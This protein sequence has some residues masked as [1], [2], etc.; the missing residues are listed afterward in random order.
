MSKPSVAARRVK[1]RGIVQGVG[2][3]P[4]IYGLAQRLALCG[5]VRNTSAGVEIV[6]EGAAEALDAFVQAISAEAPPLARVEHVHAEAVPPNGYTDFQIRHSAA[7][8]G[9]YQL[10]SPDVAT[11]DECLAEIFDPHNRRYRYAFTNCTNCGPRFTIIRDIPYDRPLTTMADFRM[12]ADCQREYDDPLDRRFHAQPNACPTCGPQLELRPSP[13][14]PLPEGAQRARSGGVQG[15]AS[16]AGGAGGKAPASPSDPI[17]QARDLLRTGHIV[18]VKGL[19]GFHLA[20]DATAPQVVA[21]LRAR[22][23]RPHKPF[24]VMMPN[25]ATV[26]R[27]CHVTETAAEW[28]QSKE[29][30]IVLLPLRAEAPIAQNVAP[31]LRELGVM[32]PYTPLHHLLLEPTGDFPPALVM[33]SGNLSDEPIVTQNAAALEKLAPLADAFLLHDRAIHVRCDDSVVRAHGEQITPIRRSRG[34]V[35]NPLP[36]PFE[37]PP[38]LAVGAELKNTFCLAR[39]R[40]AF[41]SQHIGDL[42]N[43]D[44]LQAYERAVAH[45]EHIFRLRPQLLVHDLHPNYMATRYAERRADREDLARLAVQ[46]HHAHLAACIAEHAL[47]ADAHVIGVIFDGTG[48]GTDGA[49]WGGEVL[50]GGYAGFRRFA[51]LRY[52]PLPGGDAATL[53]PYRTALAHLWA[54]GLP[55]ETDLPPVQAANAQERAVIRQ[56]LEKRLN[57]PLTSS[58]GRLFD[59]AAALVGVLQRVSYEAQGAIWLEAQCDPQEHGSYPLEIVPPATPNAPHQLDPAPLWRA[60]LGDLRAGVDVPRMAARFHNGI[61]DAVVRLCRLAREHSGLNVVALSGGVF[62]NAMLL[63]RVVAG[64]RR[65]G[66]TVYAHRRVPPND[67]GLALGQAA[68][69]A[70]RAQST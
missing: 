43:Y 62:Q 54:A 10:I 27:F 4:F 67:G 51:H 19:G 40:H 36:L 44:A 45:M 33:T 37:S 66:F 1:V 15:T 39:E 53:R 8:A 65:A 2:F 64:L 52:I 46:H 21:E 57:A 29:R 68:I 28:L 25:L 5:W 7:I 30:P 24:A 34:Y 23:R 55:W 20:C 49:I 26:R 56:Q 38:L 61:A 48:L 3:R 14:A 63:E 42:S 12:C 69:A 31:G 41:P 22:K 17:A 32:L 6:V 11:C 9:A 70:C 47:P 59:A 18:A 35:P 13:H 16:P 58:M 60:L 50:L